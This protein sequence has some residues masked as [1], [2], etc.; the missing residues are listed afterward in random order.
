MQHFRFASICILMVRPC[1]HNT[2]FSHPYNTAKYEHMEL[3][4]HTYTTHTHTHTKG[5]KNATEGLFNWNQFFIDWMNRQ[6]SLLWASIAFPCPEQHLLQSH[7]MHT[8]NV[9]FSI[10]QAR[11]KTS[12]VL[13]SLTLTYFVDAPF[14]SYTPRW[15]VIEKKM[16]FARNKHIFYPVF[17]I[18]INI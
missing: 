7:S 5:E 15:N 12:N 6:Y 3:D 14:Y 10:V 17:Q 8:L 4:T 16:T 18:N 11:P 2:C 13:F 9:R 1:L